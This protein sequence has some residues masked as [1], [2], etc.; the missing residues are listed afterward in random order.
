MIASPAEISSPSDFSHETILPSF[1][2]DDNAGMETSTGSA[3]IIKGVDIV[4]L[5]FD[6]LNWELVTPE[7]ATF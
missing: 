1:I 6:G 7:K 3:A 5:L 2:V 4:V